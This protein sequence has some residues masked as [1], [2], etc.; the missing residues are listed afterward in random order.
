MAEGDVTEDRLVGAKEA[1]LILGVSVKSLRRMAEVRPVP[2]PI[3]GKRDRPRW[4]VRELQEVIERWK[5][6]RAS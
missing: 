6:R 1:A 2:V 4:S 5:Q 3:T